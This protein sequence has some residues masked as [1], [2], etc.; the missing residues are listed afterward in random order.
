MSVTLYGVGSPGMGEYS[1]ITVSAI[2][3]SEKTLFV[4][5][6]TMQPNPTGMGGFKSDYLLIDTDFYTEL[7]F[8]NLIK[9]GRG[10][11]GYRFGLYKVLQ[12]VSKTE[13]GGSYSYFIQYAE[14]NKYN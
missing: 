7:P 8:D 6:R 1:D 5:D 10:K 13:L 12:K 3:N 4:N 2:S 9:L 11:Q 14:K